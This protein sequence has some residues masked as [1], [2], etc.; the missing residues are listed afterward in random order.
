[1]SSEIVDIFA[2]VVAQVSD[3]LHIT[4]PDGSGDRR[5]ITIT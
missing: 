4:V 1:M 3:G 2:D 5:T